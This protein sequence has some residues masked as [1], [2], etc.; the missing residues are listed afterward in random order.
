MHIAQ[1]QKKNQ[2]EDA[3][4]KSIKGIEQTINIQKKVSSSINN[5][6]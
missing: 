5:K 2:A 3:S 4:P 1:Q 6:Q